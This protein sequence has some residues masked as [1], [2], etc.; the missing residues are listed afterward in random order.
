MASVEFN[1]WTAAVTI[2]LAGGGAAYLLLRALKAFRSSAIPVSAAPESNNPENKKG[3]SEFVIDTFGHLV[4]RLREKEQELEKLRAEA[5]HRASR[6]ENDNKTLQEQ[7]EM[8]KR[9]ALLG[10][11]SAGIAHEFRNSMGTILGYTRLLSRE[12]P[13]DTPGQKF[14]SAIAEEIETLNTIIRDL[15][16]YG[17]PLTLHPTPGDLDTLIEKAV[18]AAQ[19]GR[20]YVP[21]IV[22]HVP[23][24]CSVRM[25][26]VLMRQAIAN[27]VQNAMEA[28][29]EG[30]PLSI[31]CRQDGEDRME[32]RVSDSG[33]GI[34]EENLEKIFLPFFTTKPKGTGMGLALVHKI[35]LAH[36]GRILVERRPGKGTTFVITLPMY[37]ERK[38]ILGHHPDH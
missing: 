15:L 37:G 26:E 34:P 14:L 11:M 3:K 31:E 32:V 23:P 25:D 10:E 4:Q 30:G 20:S 8:N 24:S 13:V 36:G 5:E 7:I 17:K 29:P 27:L 12:I 9:L 16:D 22:V 21:E 6:A 33:P 19:G 35:V 28:M 18:A 1:H 2:L 38:S